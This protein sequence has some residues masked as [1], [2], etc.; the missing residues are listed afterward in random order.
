ML[1]SVR[2]AFGLLL[3]RDRRVYVALTAAQMAT[4]VLELAGVLLLGLVGALATAAVSGEAVPSSIASTLDRI[5]LGQVPIESAAAWCA[6]IAAVLLIARTAVSSLLMKSTLQFLA[7]CQGE[8][9]GRLLAR[10]MSR[11]I[12][13]VQRESSQKTAYALTMGATAVVTGLLGAVSLIL[14]DLAVLTLLTLG[15]LAIDPTVTLVAVAY[16]A[17]VAVALHR[18][19]SSWA[20]RI[21][22]SSG[23]TSITAMTQ[24]QEGLASYRELW[25]LGRRQRF[26]DATHDTL[27]QASR[28]R[29]TMAFIGQLPKYAY[30]TAVVVGALLLV[31]WQVRSTTLVDALATLVL[32]LAAGSR[33]VPSMLRANGQLINIR[34]M[35]RQADPLNELVALVSSPTPDGWQLLPSAGTTPSRRADF[36]PVIEVRDVTFAYPAAERPALDRVSFTV[37]QGRSVAIVGTTGSGKSTLADLIIGLLPPA[38]GAVLISGEPPSLAIARWPGAMSYVPQH[39]SLVNGTVRDNVALAINPDEVDEHAVW[40]ALGR[41]ELAEFVGQLPDGIATTIGERGVR[42]SGGQRQRLG[43]ARALLSDPQVLILDEATSALDA[44]TEHAVAASIAA[45][46]GEVTVV[47]IAHRLAT[48]RQVDSVVYLE[49]GRVTA[50]GTF[51]E[52]RQAVPAFDRQADLMGLRR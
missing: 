4:A 42:L 25:T 27:L 51:D 45:L 41:V 10:L 31:V 23:T 49:D 50:Q 47:V 1:T 7:K 52:V 11:P 13:D 40:R 44:D 29:G 26:L 5:G 16:F 39:V 46:E 43:L 33:L 21:G 24:V 8:L 20:A 9:A 3:P 38:S 2:A 15:L 30:D 32:M 17:L 36:R 22:K 48:V 37:A 14:S 35:A 12:L 34:S 18:S 28:T 19:L 6:A